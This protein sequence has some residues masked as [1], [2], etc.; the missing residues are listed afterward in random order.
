[1]RIEVI[2]KNTDNKDIM[3]PIHYNELIQ[4]IIYKNLPKLLSTFLHDIGF[5]YNN[6]PIKLFTFSK[7]FSNKIKL[8]KNYIFFSNTISI[9]ISSPIEIIIK[10]LRENLLKNEIIKLNVN[11]LKVDEIKTVPN[12]KF[13]N[14]MKIKTLSPITIYKTIIKNDKKYT[15][16]I[17][18]N[19]NEFNYLIK[20]NI[21]K[22]YVIIQGIIDKNISLDFQ[23]EIR[24]INIKNKI[25]KYKNFIIKGIEG[26]LELATDKPEI[27]EKVYDAG[28]GAKNSQGFGMFQ[29]I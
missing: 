2:L 14:I 22:K 4:K 12:P 13:E 8:Y 3:L 17:F 25:L 20:E 16:Y 28:L 5:R 18:P 29:I 6:K 26:E 10:I 1:M 19:D 7:I 27:I 15:N 21:K 11:K 9:F 24:P 23:L